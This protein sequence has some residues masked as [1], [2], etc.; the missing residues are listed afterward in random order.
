MSSTM[1]CVLRAVVAM[2]VINAYSGGSRVAFHISEFGDSATTHWYDEKSL[3]LLQPTKPAIPPIRWA[4]H[5]LSP[6][7]LKHAT[8]DRH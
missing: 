5:T 1:L 6:G 4:S 2:N 7:W 8:A 3:A